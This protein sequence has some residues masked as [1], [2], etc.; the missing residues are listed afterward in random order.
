M[1][2]WYHN[3]TS[4]RRLYILLLSADSVGACLPD[5]SCKKTGTCQKEGGCF[6]SD[7]LYV[8]LLLRTM[9]L[10]RL[11]NGVRMVVTIALIAIVMASVISIVRSIVLTRLVMTT[12]SLMNAVVYKA[13]MVMT[14][15][16]NAR[17]KSH[18]I[19]TVI[20]ML[21]VWIASPLMWRRS[22]SVSSWLFR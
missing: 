14:V 7:P 3:W 22:V 17:M 11:A 16:L 5:K 13:I 8:R 10:E 18:A 2:M 12:P 4:R 1:W 19:I 21:K 20:V 9:L 6:C 15:L